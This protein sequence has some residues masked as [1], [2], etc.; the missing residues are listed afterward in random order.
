MNTDKHKFN[1]QQT[2]Y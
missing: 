2:E 1:T